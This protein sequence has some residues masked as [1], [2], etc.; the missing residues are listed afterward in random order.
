MLVY[1]YV[2]IEYDFITILLYVNLFLSYVNMVCGLNI[3]YVLFCFK[4]EIDTDDTI[5]V[6]FRSGAGFI[7][8]LDISLEH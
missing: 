6:T 7:L 8:H 5:G 3:C 1:Y 2:Y 4:A